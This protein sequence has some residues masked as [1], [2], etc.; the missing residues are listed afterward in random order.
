MTI[1]R[2]DVQR[3]FDAEVEDPVLVL[4]EG[5][6]L[7]ISEADLADGRYAGALEIG[8]RSSLVSEFGDEG[9]AERD[10][11]GVAARWDIEV[12]QRGG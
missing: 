11:A 12:T 8:S 6:T 5:R 7:V 3:L 10:L 9:P 4:Q 1:T 2:E